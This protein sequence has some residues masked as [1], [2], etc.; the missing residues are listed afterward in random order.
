MGRF[1]AEVKNVLTAKIKQEEE[2]KE[3]VTEKIKRAKKKSPSF[4]PKNKFVLVCDEWAA[5]CGVNDNDELKLLGYLDLETIK[6][7]F[8]E[9]TPANKP[10]LLCTPLLPKNCIF[11]GQYPDKKKIF[12]CEQA[13]RKQTIIFQ[14]PCASK[15]EAVAAGHNLKPTQ[16]YTYY[17]VNIPYTLQLP[18]LQYYFSL[19]ED[20]YSKKMYLNHAK[21]SCTT[22]P[23]TEETDKVYSLPLNNI[24]PYYFDI[25]WGLN[26]VPDFNMKVSKYI[27][28]LI[29]HFW[30]LKFNN[31]YTPIYPDLFK[32]Y[33]TWQDQTEESVLKAKYSV[34]RRSTFKEI[35]GD[36]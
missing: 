21:I 16:D 5:A 23:I 14:R 22:V 32:N 34:G 19:R 18:Y 30:S 12:V 13:P 6:N 8:E 35:I 4:I 2:T 36:L 15:E 9:P 1:T 25:C 10:P 3:T 24:E 27:E 17:T 20:T 11:Y 33:T 29:N 28:L 7:C 31:H 26:P